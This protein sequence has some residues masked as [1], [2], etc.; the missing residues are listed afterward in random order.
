MSNKKEPG[1]IKKFIL[2]NF[3]LPLFLIIVGALGYGYWYIYNLPIINTLSSNKD[4]TVIFFAATL[5]IFSVMT[6]RILLDIIDLTFG[7]KG[8][9]SLTKKANRK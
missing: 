3:R 9:N 8:Q 7:Q 5:I 4:Y 1:A 6:L 2:M